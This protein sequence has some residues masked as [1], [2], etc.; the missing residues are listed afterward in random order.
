MA[1]VLLCLPVQEAVHLG[2]GLGTIGCHCKHLLDLLTSLPL[3]L[4]LSSSPKGK[5]E[6]VREHKATESF[7]LLRLGKT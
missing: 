7:N 2:Y 1:E 5:A 6:A 4:H 3:I